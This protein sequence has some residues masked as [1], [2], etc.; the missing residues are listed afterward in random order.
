MENMNIN[1]MSGINAPGPVPSRGGRGGVLK[2]LIIVI[3]ALIVIWGAVKLFSRV[4]VSDED[5]ARGYSVESADEGEVVSSFPS[6]FLVEPNAAV[7]GSYEL[8][9]TNGRG[10]LPTV[11]YTSERSLDEN[12]ALFKG[13]LTDGGWSITKEATSE[14]APTTNF[15]ALRGGNDVNITLTDIEG[16]VT[17]HIAYIERVPMAE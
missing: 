3:V 16:V 7:S 13:I 11:E 14:E 15:Y 1:P 9:Y 5:A 12:I 10:T 8:K 2:T 6:E 4:G 17:V